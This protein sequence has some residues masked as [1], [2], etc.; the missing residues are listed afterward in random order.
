MSDE[1]SSSTLESPEPGSYII[2]RANPRPASRRTAV[3][4]VAAGTRVVVGGVSSARAEGF[5]VLAPLAIV[6]VGRQCGD[7][8]DWR[9]DRVVRKTHGG[10][11]YGR[12]ETRFSL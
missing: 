5:T 10:I 2:A 1:E 3:D 6:S 4:V 11:N 7:I 9:G 12:E 8:F